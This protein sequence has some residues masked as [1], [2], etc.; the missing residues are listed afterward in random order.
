VATVAV[1]L[2]NG[3]SAIAKLQGSMR[4][5]PRV[6]LDNVLYIQNFLCN[7]ISVAQLI[8]ELK[9]IVIVDNDLCVIQ[10]CTSKNPIG[11]GRLR[12]GVYCFENFASSGAQVNAVGLHNLWHERLGHPSNQVLSLLSKNLKITCSVVNKGPFCLCAKQTCT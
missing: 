8:R 5:S 7:L 1:S 4:L 12:G 3:E 11:V 6:N 9:C 10:D 2:T